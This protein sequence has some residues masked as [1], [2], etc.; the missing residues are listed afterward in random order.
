MY[1]KTTLTRLPRKVRASQSSA[2]FLDDVRIKIGRCGDSLIH[3]Q[4]KGSVLKDVDERNVFI[5]S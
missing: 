5:E 3:S 2:F 4:R 1:I